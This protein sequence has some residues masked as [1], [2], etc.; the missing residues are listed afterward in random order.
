MDVWE[1]GRAGRWKGY[2]DGGRKNGWRV[3]RGR[4]GEGN[5]KCA[6]NG[7]VGAGKGR[8]RDEGE[9]RMDERGERVCGRMVER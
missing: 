8:V 9:G 5:V 6:R 7:C 2:G 4:G 3:E 1:Q